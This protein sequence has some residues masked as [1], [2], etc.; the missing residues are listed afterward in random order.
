MTAIRKKLTEYLVL[1][2]VAL[3]V[4]MAIHTVTAHSAHTGDH[5]CQIATEGDFYATVAPRK[6]IIMV[7]NEAA[8]RKIVD[9]F[10]K[11]RREQGVFQLEIDT[12]VIGIFQ[13]A[14]QLY[15]GT[16]AFKDRCVVP[17]TVTVVEAPKW[18]AFTTSLGIQPKDFSE[19]KDG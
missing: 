8:E 17:G 13:E 14:G 1:A 9:A 4:V 15:I 7:A 2:F 5:S 16:V 12:F 3:V 11:T 18:V 6:P 19:M 10:N